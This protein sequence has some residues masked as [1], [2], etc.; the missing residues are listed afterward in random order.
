MDIATYS[1]FRQN[2]K[3]FLDAVVKT[4]K[5]LFITRKQGEEL[6]VMSKEDYTSLQETL[7]LLSNPNN[8]KRL[9]E[10]ID[11]YEKGKLTRQKLAI[12]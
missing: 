7:Y 9:K 2:M 6:V 12:K 5:P 1:D 11:Q 3:S 8:S 10:S 4:H